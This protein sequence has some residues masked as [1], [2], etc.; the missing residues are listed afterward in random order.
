MTDYSP[1]EYWAGVAEGFRSADSAGFAPVLHPGAP[2]W[3]N[4]LIDALQFRAMCRA[5]VLA[6]IQQGAH[7]LDVGCGTGRWLRRYQQFGF[8]AMGLDATLGMLHTAR[9]RGTAVPLVAGEAGRLPFPDSSFD[10]VSDVTVVQ[11]IPL[12]FQP[13]ALSEM[14]RVLKP[15]GRLILI[16]VIKGRSEHVFSREPHD[17]IQQV[18]LHGGILLGWFGQEYLFLDR[19]FVI[20]AQKLRSSPASRGSVRTLPGNTTAAPP[21]FGRRAY[22]GARHLIAVLSGWA[23]P[24]FEKIFPSR[25]ATHGVFVFRK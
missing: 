19:L 22:W 21:S 15:G 13:P 18:G 8:R 9:E 11:H 2:P 5:L 3:Y 1:K 17:W 4:R 16:E 6:R 25:C 23:D 12:E 10:A 20:L 7:F 24:L 14:L